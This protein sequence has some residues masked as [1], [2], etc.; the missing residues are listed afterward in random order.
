M[1]HRVTIL[2][3]H[4]TDPAAFDDYYQRLHVPLAQAIP[5][6]STFSY[7]HCQALDGSKPPYYLAAGLSFA[8]KDDLDRALTSPEMRA[9]GMDVANFATGGVT[10][11]LV[12][13]QEAP[14]G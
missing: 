7:G 10:M 12:D 2:Y 5:G 4:P 11:L 3:G 8:T 9:A 14:L 13:D 6:V 1:T